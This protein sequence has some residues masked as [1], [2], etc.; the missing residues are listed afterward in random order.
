MVRIPTEISESEVHYFSE[1]K[2]LNN[3]KAMK[4]DHLNMFVFSATLAG[5]NLP[6]KYSFSGRSRFS[7]NL[8][9]K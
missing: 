4:V 1:R 6:K 7:V 3:L 9:V 2:F 8:R 5:I